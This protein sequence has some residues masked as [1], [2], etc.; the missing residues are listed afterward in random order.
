MDILGLCR[1]SKLVYSEDDKKIK[2]DSGL[3][4]IEIVEQGNYK[5]FI[6]EREGMLIIS[7]RGSANKPNWIRNFMINSKKGVHT[8]VSQGSDEIMKTLLPTLKGFK[9]K[10]IVFGSHSLGAGLSLVV[11]KKL[12]A[13]GYTIRKVVSYEGLRVFRTNIDFDIDTIYTVVSGD[14]VPCMPPKKFGYKSVGKRIYFNKRGNLAPY[15][16]LHLVKGVILG[17]TKKYYGIGQSHSVDTII[18]H[19]NN[20]KDKLIK[21]DLWFI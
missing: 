20:N 13:L 9:D 5:Y 15:N 8:G 17:W 1:L 6:G 16:P 4:N 3:T 7:I 10:E 19:L 21:R 14:A 12:K 18:N 11:A 2:K